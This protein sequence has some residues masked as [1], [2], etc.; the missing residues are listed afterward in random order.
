[1]TLIPG[2]VAAVLL[3]WA[4]G[5]DPARVASLR[6]RRGTIL[7]AA[8]GAQL[9]AFGPV[10][11][12]GDRQVERVQLVTYGLLLAFCI[13]N[14]RIPGLWLIA[15]GVL[16]NALVIAANG[17]AMPVDPGA[18]AAS[19]WGLHDYATAYPNVAVRAH[20]SLWFLGDVFAM[21][22][23]PGSAVLSIGDVSIVAGVWLMLQRVTSQREELGRA[24]VPRRSAF[25][26]VAG[27]GAALS[28][29]LGLIDGGAALLVAAVAAGAFLGLVALAVADRL[30]PPLRCLTVCVLLAIGAVLLAGSTGTL[31]TAI[32]GTALAGLMTMIAAIAASRLLL[33][34]W[35]SEVS[36]GG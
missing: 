6:F 32:L 4:L 3:V 20:A 28:A 34:P 35:G 7:Y 33:R 25:G 31:P 12:L 29:G 15:L 2:L 13:A 11:I 8:L 23:F 18:I 17:G 5:G 19:G 36:G 21:P 9:V 24:P 30:P 22:R 10:R 16:A 27:G 14:R 26:L 1:M